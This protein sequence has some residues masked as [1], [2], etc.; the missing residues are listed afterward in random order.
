MCWPHATS[1]TIA[2]AEQLVCCVSCLSAAVVLCKDAASCGKLFLWN[3]ECVRVHT[4][5][6]YIAGIAY[7]MEM[8]WHM[9]ACEEKG[10]R[11]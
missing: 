4:I 9:A 11:Q 2:I 5:H 10:L 8:M 7:S 6:W 3:T 1:R